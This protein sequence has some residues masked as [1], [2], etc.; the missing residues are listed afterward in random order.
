MFKTCIGDNK[1]QRES[2]L[3]QDQRVLDH[4]N[5]YCN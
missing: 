5:Y 2:K 3:I 1:D 4:A